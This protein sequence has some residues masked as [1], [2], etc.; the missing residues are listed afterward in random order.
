MK[1]GSRSEKL[2]DRSIRLELDLASLEDILEEGAVSDRL[3]AKKYFDPGRGAH[4]VVG[5]KECSQDPYLYVSRSA[6]N[7]DLN[8]TF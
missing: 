2:L 6:P 4:L 5:L 8:V 7:A 1:T 3:T